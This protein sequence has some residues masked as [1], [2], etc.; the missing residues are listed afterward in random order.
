VAEDVLHL[1]EDGWVRYVIPALQTEVRLRFTEIEGRLEVEEISIRGGGLT[2]EDLRALP[3]GSIRELANSPFWLNRVRSHTRQAAGEPVDLEGRAETADS[4]TGGLSVDEERVDAVVRP[5][6][7]A[8]G[9]QIPQVHASTDRPRKP[10]MKFR[11]PEGRRK[12]DDFYRRVAEAYSWLRGYEQ[13]RS[14]A[15]D[16]AEINGVPV[17]TVHRWVKEARRRGLLG[18][19]RPGRAG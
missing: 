13:S 9:I 19:G 10:R 11:I 16:L 8:I 3:L 18:P 17:T 2:G 15:S 12:P 7:V 14:P 5:A 1:D 4:S 6:T